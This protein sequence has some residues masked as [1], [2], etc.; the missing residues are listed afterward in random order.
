[1]GHD[2]VNLGTSVASLSSDPFDAWL[3]FHPRSMVI[4]NNEP[5]SLSWDFV[6]NSHF[7]TIGNLVSAPCH[8]RYYGAEQTVAHCVNCFTA[9]QCKT[10]DASGGFGLPICL[11][12]K[13]V[14]FKT[15]PPGIGPQSLVQVSISRSGNPFWGYQFYFD[16]HQKCCQPLTIFER[17][18]APSSSER[19]EPSR[20]TSERCRKHSPICC[21]S[22]HC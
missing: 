8:L 20:P 11:R 2:T 15:K 12:W 10:Q 5:W 6:A 19:S 14:W 1:M 4:P 17:R 18:A 3:N 7:L 22:A 21:V 16:S 9:V 13:R